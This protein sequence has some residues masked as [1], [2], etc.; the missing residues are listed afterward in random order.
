MEAATLSPPITVVTKEDLVSANELKEM[1][2]LTW[3]QAALIDYVV[4]QSAGYFA[5]LVESSFTW[6]VAMRRA[7]TRGR[8]GAVCGEV[9][10]TGEGIAWR[11]EWSEI[12]GVDPS[13]FMGKLWP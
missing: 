12:M 13:E 6:N 8:E 7:A 9:N 3:D 10:K 11:D 2:A 1:R 4:L 5:G